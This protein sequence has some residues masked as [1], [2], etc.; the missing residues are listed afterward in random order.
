MKSHN[1]LGRTINTISTIQQSYFASMAW[2][3]TDN[4]YNKKYSGGTL[5]IIKNVPG[6][7]NQ[8][9]FNP[10]YII[11]MKDKQTHFWPTQTFGKHCVFK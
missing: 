5:R 1:E 7:S 6:S 2:N 8:C 9:S 10:N 3:R 4:N 11:I